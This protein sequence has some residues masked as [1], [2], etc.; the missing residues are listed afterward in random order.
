MNFG[1]SRSD[2]LVAAPG[3]ET[4]EGLGTAPGESL[5]DRAG[6]A[7]DARAAD[8]IKE[9]AAVDDERRGADDVRDAGVCAVDGSGVDLVDGS[10]VG[11]LAPALTPPCGPAHPATTIESTAAPTR[12]RAAYQRAWLTTTHASE[13]IHSERSTRDMMAW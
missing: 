10:N 1:R 8:G 11:T 3:A 2:A 12:E 7:V 5:V 4:I 13:P 6:S 9:G